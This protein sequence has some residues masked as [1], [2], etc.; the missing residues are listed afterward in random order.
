MKIFKLIYQKL[1]VLENLEKMNKKLLYLDKNMKIVFKISIKIINYEKK[2]DSFYRDS[3]HILLFFERKK[4]EIKIKTTTKK[5]FFYYII[6]VFVV[7]F[8]FGCSLCQ[9]TFFLNRN[10]DFTI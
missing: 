2:K 4:N 7:F 3:L 5:N 9:F 8:F 6:R 1:R 10:D